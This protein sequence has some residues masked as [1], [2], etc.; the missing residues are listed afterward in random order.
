VNQ[1]ENK[2]QWKDYWTITAEYG[3]KKRT[4]GNIGEAMAVAGCF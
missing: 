1:H 3:S 4:H 2:Q